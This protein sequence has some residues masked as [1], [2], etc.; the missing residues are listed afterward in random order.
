MKTD[1]RVNEDDLDWDDDL[2][3][4]DSTPYS[5]T[6]FLLYPDGSLKREVT[7]QNGFEEGD[8]R[9]W[10]PNGNLRREW[11]AERGRATGN[12]KEWHADG[13]VKSVGEYEFGVELQYDEWNESGDLVAHRRIDEN[14]RSFKYSQRKRNL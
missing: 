14:T 9:E 10:H 5:G 1:Q 13:T 7:Y 8:C 6:A 4:L 3:V 12:V 2:S 11:L